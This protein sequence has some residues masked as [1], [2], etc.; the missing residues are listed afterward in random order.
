MKG[1]L[2]RWPGGDS[3]GRNPDKFR[4]LGYCLAGQFDTLNRLCTEMA[5]KPELEQEILRI[6]RG[7][8]GR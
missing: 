7:D 4:R 3:P 6:I 1:P 8:N 5:R 2:S